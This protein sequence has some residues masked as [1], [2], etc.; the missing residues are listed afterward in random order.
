MYV[1]TGLTMPTA[2]SPPSGGKGGATASPQSPDL[3]KTRASI[4]EN[5]F[6]SED[7][8]GGDVSKGPQVIL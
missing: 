6:R 1:P 3:N 8:W 4:S 2:S 7:R 5:R